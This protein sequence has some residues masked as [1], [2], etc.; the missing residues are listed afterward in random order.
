LKA[1]VYATLGTSMTAYDQM[2]K[3][4]RAVIP[5]P[6]SLRAVG[7]LYDPNLSDYGEFLCEQVR[8]DEATLRLVRLCWVSHERNPEVETEWVVED[9]LTGQRYTRLEI[10][11]GP[12]VWTP[13]EVLAWAAED[14]P[15]VDIAGD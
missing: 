15:D 6:K 11:L 1:Q 8:Q 10:D 14:H 7:K 5:D 2:S 12:R 4:A 13:L 3:V 9:I